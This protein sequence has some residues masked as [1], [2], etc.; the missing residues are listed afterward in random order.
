MGELGG[1]EGG[2]E[3]DRQSESSVILLV[4]TF[5]NYNRDCIDVSGH[6]S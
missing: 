2:T 5:F 1:R 4:R 3:R 6:M